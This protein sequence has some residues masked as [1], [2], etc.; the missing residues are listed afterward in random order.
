MIITSQTIHSLNVLTYSTINIFEL[1]SFSL[2]FILKRKERAQFY[3][4]QTHTFLSRVVLQQVVSR[5]TE[6]HLW[7]SCCTAFLASVACACTTRVDPR[8]PSWNTRMCVAPHKLWPHCKVPSYSP[9]TVVPYV[10]STPKAK[11]LQRSVQ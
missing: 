11:W 10:S 1:P 2:V 6:P 9:Q 7:C 5:Y 4:T 3:H 8:W